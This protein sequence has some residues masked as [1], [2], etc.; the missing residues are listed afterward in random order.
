MAERMWQLRLPIILLF[1][2]F[3][4][5]GRFSNFLC[6]WR[7]NLFCP[8]IEHVGTNTM[9]MWRLN[10]MNPLVVPAIYINEDDGKCLVLKDGGGHHVVLAHMKYLNETGWKRRP[11]EKAGQTCRVYRYMKIYTYYSHSLFPLILL[12]NRLHACLTM[13][14]P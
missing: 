8:S 11:L 12:S 9:S 1:L 6:W 3:V 7:L 5:G 14:I 13:Q 10:I 4:D 2:K